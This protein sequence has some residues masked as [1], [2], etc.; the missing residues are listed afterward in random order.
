[1]QDLE[2]WAGPHHE[3][4]TVLAK[5]EDQSVVAPWRSGESVSDL[6][7]PTSVDLLAGRCVVRGQKA[8]VQQRVV[9]I[10]IDQ[11]RGAVGTKQRVGPDD[12][13]VPRI[14]PGSRK[15]FL[16]TAGHLLVNGDVTSRPWLN[17]INRT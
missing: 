1:M 9:H 11:R 14:V 2:F 16:K 15:T 6:Q 5:K 4:V 8:A 17:R 12:V 7:S 13:V 10:V 3:R